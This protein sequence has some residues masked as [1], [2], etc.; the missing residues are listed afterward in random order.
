MAGLYSPPHD[1]LSP[2]LCRCNRSSPLSIG[3][4]E[5]PDLVV[6]RVDSAC[7]WLALVG[8]S[9]GWEAALRRLPLQLELTLSSSVAGGQ[10]LL[11]R[12]GSGGPEGG[13]G[14]LLACPRQ[15]CCWER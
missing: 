6:L 4:A 8:I 11:S 14:V 1:P 3:I 10:I 9:A 12:A 7:P 5:G 15:S 2:S 13:S